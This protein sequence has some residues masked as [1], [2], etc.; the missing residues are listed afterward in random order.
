GETIIG[1][2]TVLDRGLELAGAIFLRIDADGDI[3]ERIDARSAFLREGHWELS[4]ASVIRDGSLP[5]RVDRVEIP[6][7]LTPEFVFER[8][9]NPETIPIYELPRKIEAARSYGLGANAFAMH[10]HS[11]LALPVLL[12]AMTLIAATVSMRFAR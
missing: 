1:A 4:E 2:H 8:L 12:V 5:E 6:T 10:F 7:N 3:Y 9:A 11:L